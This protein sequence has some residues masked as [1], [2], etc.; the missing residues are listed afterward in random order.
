MHYA[1]LP[2][3]RA[4]ELM[5]CQ[6]TDPA[7]L[8][9]LVELHKKMGLVSSLAHGR[10]KG[11][12][13]DR[14]WAAL[15]REVLTLLAEGVSNP[16]EIDGLWKEMFSDPSFGPCAMMDAEG[17]EEVAEIE[18][19]YIQERHLDSTFT[20][21]YLRSLYLQEGRS[22]AESPKGGLIPH[23]ISYNSTNG[24]PH[25]QLTST[26]PTLFF[27]DVGVGEN[28]N[29]M[30]E[31]MTA[32][33]IL[34][35]SPDGKQINTIITGQSYP[36]GIDVSLR[37]GRI[38]WTN[39][40]VT[41][42][43]DGAVM[44]ANL[45]G[46]D[47]RSI[48][49]KGSVHTPK[50]LAIDHTNSHLYFSDREGLCVSRCN[51]DGSNLE[52]LIQTGDPANPSHTT[53]PLRFCIGVTVDPAKQ[54]FYW[55]QKGPSKAGKGRIFRAGMTIPAN[56]TPA[57]RPDIE[58]LFS[59][60]PECV[61]LEYEPHSQSLWWTDRGEHPGGNSLNVS[62]VG[63]HDSKPRNPE[64]AVMPQRN[65]LTRHLHEAIGLRLDTR[66][67]CVYVC[68]LGGSVYCVG[69]DGRGKR[70]VWRSEAAFTGIAVAY[71]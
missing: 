34:S 52:T 56:S 25:S 4:V 55:T 58:L 31:A 24:H 69:M 5:P 65:I 19:E 10:S 67:R 44:S 42:V 45:D 50:Q 68:D 2:R 8:P 48:V 12:A 29:S 27:L 17:L 3:N 66:N 22:G 14:I 53:D 57:T 51:F 63:P 6:Q 49:P 13:L 16:E 41:G 40:G 38:F 62:Y 20:S 15:K 46:S 60:L 37:A 35:T 61:D 28:V 1:L 21:D 43:K 11:M 7:I 54:L 30:D 18:D 47:I 70:V 26:Q 71:L 33:K 59:N 32:G 36:D 64:L 9:F 39:M 23:K